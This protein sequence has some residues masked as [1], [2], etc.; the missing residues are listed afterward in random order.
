[1]RLVGAFYRLN[2]EVVE[3]S[4][5]AQP[6]CVFQRSTNKP[7]K[8]VRFDSF[9]VD[10]PVEVF[11]ELSKGI[12]GI[13]ARFVARIGDEKLL[14]EM[15]TG[16]L[17]DFFWLSLL[18]FWR[19]SHNGLVNVAKRCPDI[20]PHVHTVGAR[21]QYALS[22]WRIT[23]GELAFRRI[24]LLP[25]RRPPCRRRIHTFRS[26][27]RASRNIV[28]GSPAALVFLLCSYRVV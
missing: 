20:H 8:R 10:S 1:M 12:F 22:R 15:H 18:C 25:I 27:C 13:R 3:L 23:R 2:F 14:C 28:P 17:V 21:L 7:S 26:K 24:A 4:A 16:S 19:A 11:A 5:P 9:A 6:L